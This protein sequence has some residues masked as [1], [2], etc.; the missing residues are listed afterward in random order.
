MGFLKKASPEL[1]GAFVATFLVWLFF[2]YLYPSEPLNVAETGIVF[3]ALF[4]LVRAAGWLV[5]RVLGSR[6]EQNG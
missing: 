1:L 5:R 6:R 3:V 4:L 2:H